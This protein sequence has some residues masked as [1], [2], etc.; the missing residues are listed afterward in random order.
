VISFD[1]NAACILITLITTK[2][3]TM[4]LVC[5]YL[6]YLNETQHQIGLRYISRIKVKHITSISYLF[7]KLTHC[8]LISSC[9]MCYT[10]LLLHTTLVC[11]TLKVIVTIILINSFSLSLHKNAFSTKSLV[12]L[13]Q[14]HLHLPSPDSLTLY[15]LALR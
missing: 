15:T 1:Y 5:I 4:C 11:C 10:F 9:N 8:S 2:C 6:A 13:L 7:L 3:I 14:H 12:F